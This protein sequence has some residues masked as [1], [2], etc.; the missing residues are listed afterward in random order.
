M[1][2]ETHGEGRRPWSGRAREAE[3]Q[4]R[5]GLGCGL[6]SDLEVV[7]LLVRTVSVEP[8]DGGCSHIGGDLVPSPANAKDLE[9]D[10]C[11]ETCGSRL[12]IL[13][14]L[15]VSD[16]PLFKPDTNSETP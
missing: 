8:N 1:R 16:V 10:S 14:A 15:P 11:V 12:G 4:A 5:G 9:M 7:D 3:S 13:W 2:H 6:W